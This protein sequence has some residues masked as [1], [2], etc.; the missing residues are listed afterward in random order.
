[1]HQRFLSVGTSPRRGR[2]GY[3]SWRKGNEG[4]T[5]GSSCRSGLD[6]GGLVG[7]GLKKTTEPPLSGPS[8]CKERQSETE[9]TDP[10]GVNGP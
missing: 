1:M 10:G 6:P 5:L 2:Q 3:P 8:S 4:R 9:G 7:H